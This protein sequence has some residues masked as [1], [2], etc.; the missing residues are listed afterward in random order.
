MDEAY[1]VGFNLEGQDVDLDPH[2]HSQRDRPRR[3]LAG[4]AGWFSDVVLYA[5]L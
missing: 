1:Y 5:G 2:S 3:L 4:V